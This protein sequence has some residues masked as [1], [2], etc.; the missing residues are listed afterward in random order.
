MKK[1]H[2]L[3]NRVQSAFRDV[4]STTAGAAGRGGGGS[5]WGGGGVVVR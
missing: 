2:V 4:T 3:P 1:F 5:G